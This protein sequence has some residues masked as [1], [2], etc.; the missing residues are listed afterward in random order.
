MDIFAWLTVWIIC[1][2]VA[3]GISSSKGRPY[4]EGFIIGLLLGIIGVIVVAVLP[5]NDTALEK[6]R[7]SNGTG[8]KCPYCAEIIKPEAIVC[9]YCGKELPTIKSIMIELEEI[10]NEKRI[11]PSKIQ[12]E[13]VAK[14][15]AGFSKIG[16]L[17]EVG[18]NTKRVLSLSS[19][20]YGITRDHLLCV[21][22]ADA[23]GSRI[24]G[25]SF[26]G[27]NMFSRFSALIATSQ[28][29]ILVRPDK[30]LVEDFDYQNIQKV[31]R[32][33]KAGTNAYR[34]TSKLGDVAIIFTEYQNSD[35][36]KI[37]NL[38]FDRIGF[39]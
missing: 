30:G 20:E 8:K 24:T 14:W 15:K 33:K 23:K 10:T 32:G 22:Y 25:L 5:R 29:L 3:G 35:D 17:E 28:K 7:L 39:V 21:T 26:N 6:A 12:D 4:G 11:N 9:R 16:W 37:V 38:F 2:F 1:A 31:E 18:K 34:I 19:D 13:E 27:I 36:E